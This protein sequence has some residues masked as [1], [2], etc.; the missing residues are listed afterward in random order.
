M[1]TALTDQHRAKVL[2]VLEASDS[3]LSAAEI[4]EQ[5]GIPRVTV[6][7]HLYDLLEL[8]CVTQ[9]PGT[10]PPRWNATH[11]VPE[12][13]P[14]SCGASPERLIVLVD[15]GTVHDC[16]QHLAEYVDRDDPGRDLT[17]VAF[18]DQGFNGYGVNPVAPPSIHVLRA[19]QPDPNFSDL[20][21]VATVFSQIHANRQSSPTFVIATKDRRFKPLKLLAEREGCALSLV[22]NWQELRKFVE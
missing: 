2:A 6:N 13:D 5:S 17:V 10:L 19:A 20:E 21:L 16:L 9:Q 12:R 7:H 22:E 4:S 14:V 3:G 15:L 1:A 11:K 8:G 18:A